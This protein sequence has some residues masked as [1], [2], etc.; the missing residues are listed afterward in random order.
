MD[1]LRRALVVMFALAV[2]VGAALLVLP[3]AIAADPA[4]RRASFAFAGFLV[5]ALAQAD[6]DPAA[7]REA[8]ELM[9]FVWT[10]AV[11]V[12]AAPLFI[13]A[14][15]GE[16]AN[17]RS[18]VWHVGATAVGAAAAPWIARAAFG[19]SRLADASAPELRLALAFFVTGAAA[20]GV[21][22]LTA[23]RGRRPPHD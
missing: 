7:A 3:L 19:S 18:P 9:R 11:V 20:G 4:L 14:A 8:A 2:A 22:W 15:I 10:S 13:V 12:C 5:E 16:A 21:Y 1:G 6:L 17:V 23:G